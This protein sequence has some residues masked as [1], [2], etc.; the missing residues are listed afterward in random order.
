MLRSTLKEWAHR[1]FQAPKQ[2]HSTVRSVNDL[3]EDIKT[4]V[5]G[6]KGKAD[7]QENK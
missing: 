5:K 1:G 4:N 2:F 6:K 7:D 3:F